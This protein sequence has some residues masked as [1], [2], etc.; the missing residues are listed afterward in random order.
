MRDWFEPFHSLL[1]QPDNP[2][3]ASDDDDAPSVQEQLKTEICQ[4]VSMYA[5]K[6]DEEFSVSEG[7]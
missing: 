1:T 6:Y 7:S 2:A 3:V 5:T 4:I